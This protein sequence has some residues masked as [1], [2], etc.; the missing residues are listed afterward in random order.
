MKDASTSRSAGRG[1]PSGA[2]STVRDRLL[3][4]TLDLIRKRG[5]NGFSYRDLA[6]RVGVK[7]SSIHYYFPTKEDLALEAVNAY[8]ARAARYLDGI[9]PALPPLQQAERYLASWR[10]ECSGQQVCLAGMLSTEALCLPPAV[11]HA[12][13]EFHRINESWLTALLERAR[14]QNGGEAQPAIGSAALAQVLFAALQN[15]LVSVRLFN[16]AER[17]EPAANLLLAAVAESD[18]AARLSS[19][20]S[21]AATEA[22]NAP[23]KAQTTERASEPQALN[24]QPQALNDEPQALNDEPEALNAA[25]A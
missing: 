8:S 12:L 3:E 18:A 20:S 14:A 4:H 25:S 6:E 7:T 23:M 17:L 22:R 9:D 21:R 13:Q 15:S 16:Q 24:D 5:F 10:R 19:A 1:H 11:H 2:S